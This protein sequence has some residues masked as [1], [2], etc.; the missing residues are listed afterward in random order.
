MCEPLTLTLT[1]SIH[2]YIV[3]VKEEVF[4]DLSANSHYVFNV[5]ILIRD[6][7]FYSDLLRS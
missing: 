7:K 6:F 3:L 5:F 2:C 1:H 4:F